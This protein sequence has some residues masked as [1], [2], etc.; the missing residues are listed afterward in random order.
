MFSYKRIRYMGKQAKGEEKEKR[1]IFYLKYCPSLAITSVI[2]AAA[3]S[4]IRLFFVSL[5]MTVLD[6][7]ERSGLTLIKIPK[8]TSFTVTDVFVETVVVEWQKKGR[9]KITNT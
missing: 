6:N 2:F 5:I 1:K 4:D 9:R 7:T 8:C 3:L